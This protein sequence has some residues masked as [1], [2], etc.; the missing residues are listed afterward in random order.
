MFLYRLVRD[1]GTHTLNREYKWDGN[2]IITI[3]A[4]FSTYSERVRTMSLTPP[5]TIFIWPIFPSRQNARK[6]RDIKNAAYDDEL[7]TRNTE[8]SLSQQAGTGSE[9]CRIASLLH[10]PTKF[11]LFAAFGTADDPVAYAWW[12][13]TPGRSVQQWD[14]DE[15]ERFSDN[16]LKLVNASHAADWERFQKR[17]LIM[18]SRDLLCKC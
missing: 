5:A 3:F 12:N 11:F 17:R 15:A 9:D 8:L 4:V 6:M 13:F 16:A 7:S 14:A 10:D 1:Q 2:A 18:G